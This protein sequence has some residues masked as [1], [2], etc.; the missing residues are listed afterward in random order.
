MDVSC[1]MVDG[2]HKNSLFT[3]E[4]MGIDIQSLQIVIERLQKE[5]M[6]RKTVENNLRKKIVEL[7]EEVAMLHSVAKQKTLFS[8]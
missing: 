5:I 4:E 2:D 1:E 7:E 6:C 3:N 8:D